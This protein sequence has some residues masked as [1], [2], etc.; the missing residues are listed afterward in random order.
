[1]SLRYQ[2]VLLLALLAPMA[3][4][5]EP[6]K[7]PPEIDPAVLTEGFLV[8][9]PDL[10]WR[11]EGI[12]T[13]AQGRHAQ[14]LVQLRRAA[15]FADKPAQAMVAA[16]HWSGVGVPVDRP[17]GYAWMDLASERLYPDFVVFRERYWALLT[18]SERT[19]ALQ[20]G[21]A[22]YAEYGDRV[23][24]PRLDRTLER[25]RREITGSRTG[26]TGRLEIVPESGPLAGTG[27]TL[28]GDQYYANEYWKPELYWQLQDRIWRAPPR[29]R[30]E[31][32]APQTR[33]EAP[34]DGDGPAA[35]PGK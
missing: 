7:S 1:M 23:A 3:G 4:A 31:V 28:R 12:R 35:D 22:I 16:L 24:K 27:L 18:A 6:A 17:L 29:G 20:R 10:R 5:S 21:R 25:A 9:H 11:S 32:G 33:V 34:A 19:E 13:Y 2:S 14:A 8:A 30:V 26:F 15:R